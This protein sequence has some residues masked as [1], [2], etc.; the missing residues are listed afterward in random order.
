MRK[1][2]YISDQYGDYDDLEYSDYVF[3]H[4]TSNVLKFKTLFPANETGILREGWRRKL[5]NKVFFTT[6][7]HSAQKYA[8]KASDKFGGIPIVYVVKPKGD[9]WYLH[10][11]EYVA[12]SAD[13]ISVAWEDKENYLK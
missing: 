10:S 6:S 4:G 1:K 7:M 12:D 2:R 3:Y 8:R 13:V 5:I 9:I 11:S